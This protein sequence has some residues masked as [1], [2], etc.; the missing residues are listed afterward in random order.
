[1]ST[2]TAWAKAVERRRAA[3]PTPELIEDVEWMVATGEHPARMAT[4]LGVTVRSLE[5]RLLRADRRDL[6]GYVR[7]P[8][9]A[10][11]AA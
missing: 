11:C 8:E 9:R 4:R 1:M 6:A 2:P 10:G 7:S 3:Q 5:R